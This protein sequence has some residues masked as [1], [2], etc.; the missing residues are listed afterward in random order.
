MR[1]S[2][3]SLFPTSLSPECLAWD[4]HI[5]CPYNVRL[6]S[7]S[8]SQRRKECSKVY[9]DVSLSNHLEITLRKLPPRPSAKD[10]LVLEKGLDQVT[11]SIGLKPFVHSSIRL[12]IEF[13]S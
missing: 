8:T 9:L 6:C 2:P 4:W 10:Q 5:V 1:S 3:R 7:E 11:L 12:L 13:L